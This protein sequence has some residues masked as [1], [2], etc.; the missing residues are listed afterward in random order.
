MKSGYLN[1]DSSDTVQDEI[2]LKMKPMLPDIAFFFLHK[3]CSTQGTSMLAN[4]V[5]KRYG[6]MEEDSIWR[7]NWR[8]KSAQR[9]GKWFV[10][11]PTWEVLPS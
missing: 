8:K 5:S 6:K 4:V 10:R 11:C 3:R 2:A 7:Q 9:R 1:L